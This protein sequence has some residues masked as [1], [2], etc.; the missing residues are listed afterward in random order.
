[1][2]FELTFKEG[3]VQGAE[4]VYNGAKQLVLTVR[5]RIT[6]L[7]EITSDIAKDYKIVIKEDGETVRTVA[8]PQPRP[9]ETLA[10][11][12]AMDTS[13]SM[14]EGGRIQQARAA[15]S[16]LFNNLPEQA[17]CGLILFNHQLHVVEKPSK[18]RLRLQQLI[19]ETKPD[20][21][22]A[23]LDATFEAIQMLA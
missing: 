15:A 10:V 6:G 1:Q 5:F 21:G 16:V 3:A 20:G 11:A 2:F 18:D 4:E 7:K 12:L 22:T 23:Y 9:T 14:N 17:D 8:V 19:L 13:G